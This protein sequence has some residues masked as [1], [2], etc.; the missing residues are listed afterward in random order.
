[1]Q[2]HGLLPT[3]EDEEEDIQEVPDYTELYDKYMEQQKKSG[4]KGKSG[5]KLSHEDIRN[6]STEELFSYIENESKK[7]QAEEEKRQD[8]QMLPMPESK[9]ILSMR[10]KAKN[11]IHDE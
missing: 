5:S 11:F 8:E 1:M 3:E 10:L 4:K 9:M 7:K 6:L 2:Q